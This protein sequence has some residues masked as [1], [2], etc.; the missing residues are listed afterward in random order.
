MSIAEYDSLS[1]KRF[2]SKREII[3]A[4]NTLEGIIKGIRIDKVI[5]EDEIN[6]LH[7]W[8]T[9]NDRLINKKPFTEVAFYLSV[10]IKDGILTR[11]EQKDILWLCHKYT[12]NFYQDVISSEIQVLHGIMHGIIADNRIDFIEINNLNNW[13]INNKHLNC[14][15]PYDEL[16]SLVTVV[17]QDGQL[18]PDEADLLKLFFSEF[19]DKRLSYNLND[20]Q[21][22]ELRKTLNT[23]GICAMCPEIIFEDYVFCFT[24]VSSKAKRSDIK[25]IVESKGGIFTD[26]MNRKVNYLVVG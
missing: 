17:L 19:S 6:E 4:M 10:A 22:A 12:D 20:R 15:Y 8:V 3:K 25:I 14:T 9:V 18:S 5:N 2:F 23:A 11:S 26:S 7:H 24:G 21:L 1:Y 13:L 16:C